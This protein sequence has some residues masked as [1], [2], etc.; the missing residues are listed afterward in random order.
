[1]PPAGVVAARSNPCPAFCFEADLRIAFLTPGF[2]TESNS[3]SGLGSYLDK[4][5]QA[6]LKAGHTPEIVVLSYAQ[7]QVI[8]HNGV[9]VNRVH[10]QATRGWMRW[11]PTMPAVRGLGHLRQ[12]MRIMSGAVQLAGALEARDREA[13]FD[14]I[15]SPDWEGAGLKVRPRPGRLHLVRC[16]V[17]AEL[18]ADADAQHHRFFPRWQSRYELRAVQQGDLVYAP[19]R[20]GAKY[21]QDRLGRPVHVVRPPLPVGAIPD[22]VPLENLPPRFLFHFGQIRR[23]KGFDWIAQAL[24]L[25]WR[26][27]PELK[28][29]L[30]GQLFGIDLGEWRRRWGV[31]QANVIHLG[32]LNRAKLYSVLRTAAASVL[33]SIVDNLPNTVIESLIVGV[34][35]IGTNGAS[36]DELVE[37][38]KTGELVPIND[39][40]ALADAMVRAWRDQLSSRPGFVW[41]SEIARQ[42][43]PAKAVES[44]LAL[45]QS[46]T[47]KNAAPA[48][49]PA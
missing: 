4:I 22:P 7:P 38:G 43:Q 10:P 37:H 35:V 27:E 26:Q 15:Q 46:A 33:P 24:P 12:S 6:L 14:V 8:D 29:I 1:M 48:A 20:I 18:Y 41:D 5:T 30:A 40:P 13:P 23:R 34:P 32:E 47:A 19:S 16:S 42:M 17:L 3:V 28:L 44:L 36:I 49:A 21:Y 25:C 39:I 11:C 2:V 31:H 9:R 45:I